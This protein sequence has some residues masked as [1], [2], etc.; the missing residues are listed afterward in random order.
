MNYQEFFNELLKR[1][2][3]EKPAFFKKLQNIAFI[4]LFITGIPTLAMQYGLE[5]AIP[6]WLTA[7]LAML[8]AAS[9][10]VAQFT[11]TA[12]EKVRL[13]LRE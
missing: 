11:V 3:A 1:W 2:S 4:T 13:K 10:F 6:Q 9:A 5:L 7:S 8:S 12:A